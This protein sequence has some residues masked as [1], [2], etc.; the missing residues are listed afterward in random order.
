MGRRE[1]CDR[2]QPFALAR[3]RA[4]ASGDATGRAARQGIYAV[5]LT[6]VTEDETPVDGVLSYRLEGVRRNQPTPV[7]TAPSREVTAAR[8]ITDQDLVGVR[9]IRVEGLQNA[10][11]ARR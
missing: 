10:R 5:Q 2:E 8:Q 4:R 11:V 6:P 9:A 1:C 7:G 3:R